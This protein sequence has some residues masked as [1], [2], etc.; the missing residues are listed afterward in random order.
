MTL[1]QNK[2][3]IEIQSKN[4]E[5]TVT[6]DLY[7]TRQHGSLDYPVMFYHANLSNLCMG[8]VR[9]HWHREIELMY[10]VSGCATF[11]IDDLTYELSAGNCILI[12]TN[13]MHAVRP[14]EGNDC[15][16]ISIIF[17]M[18]YLF[19]NSHSALSS[20][21][22]LP[23]TNNHSMRAI[24]LSD[25]PQALELIQTMIFENKEQVFAYEIKTKEHL[26]RL[27]ILLLEYLKEQ[28]ESSM[29][30]PLDP[31][32]SL[33]SARVKQAISYITVH[34]GENIT[35]DDIANSIHVSRGE[36]CR[37]F[38]RCLDITPFEYL[39][40]YRI[41]TATD[42]LSNLESPHS[43][44]D[45]ALMTGFNSSSYF[46]KIFRKYMNCTPSQFKRQRKEGHAKHILPT[47][48]D[49]NL[50]NSETITHS[51]H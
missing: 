50:K 51:T 6:E 40:K 16:L 32:V 45:I 3:Y 13:V 24:N 31:Q 41:Y 20:S 49:F 46:N 5:L 43:I 35:L 30:S 44:S 29:D 21:Y 2:N 1:S 33:D 11:L 19:G 38:K 14:I 18:N 23:I 27:W 8:I 28:D 36:C 47:H 25:H 48:I 4:L 15:E 42:L 37:C 17:H 22:M 34:Y 7:E 12:N 39:L 26:L 10:V 9:W